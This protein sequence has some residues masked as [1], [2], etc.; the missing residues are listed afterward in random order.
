MNRFL[1][2]ALFFWQA[3]FLN[4]QTTRGITDS[5]FQIREVTVSSNRLEYFSIGNKIRTLDSSLLNA[6]ATSNLAQTLSAYSQVQINSYG[7]GL[8]NP[9]LRGTGSSHTA[10]L[11]NGFN[12]QDLLNGGVDCSLLPMN[13]FDDIKVQYGG[14]SALYGSGAIG[15]A[16][17]L[18]NTMDFERGVSSSITTGYGS[19]GNLFGGGSLKFSNASY[20]GFVKTFYNEAQNDFTFKNMAEANFPVQRMHNA[21]RSQYGVLGG[22]AFKLGEKSKLEGFFWF[23]DNDKNVAP[24]MSTFQN[25][26]SDNQRDKFYRATASWKTWNE[27]SDFTLRTGFSNYYM[28]YDTSNFRSIQ[29]STDAEYNFKINANHL[30]N[31]GLDYTYEKGVSKSLTSNAQRNRI[32]LFTSYRFTDDQSQWKAALNIRN[33][34]INSKFTPLTFSLGIERT[35]IPSLSLKGV[36]SKNYRVPTFNDLYWINLGNPNLKCESGL[37]EELGIIFSNHIERVSIRYEL[38]GFNNMVSNWILWYPHIND[39]GNWKPENMSEVWSRGVENDLSVSFPIEKCWIKTS[40]SYSYTKS[41]KSKEDFAGDPALHKQLIYVP[42]HKG[43]LSIAIKYRGFDL[44]YGQNYAG[45]RYSEIDHSRSVK[46]YTIGNLSISKKVPFQH[47]AL[48][49]GLQA[50]NLWNADYQV[51]EYYPMPGRNFQLNICLNLN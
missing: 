26:V 31:A 2:T 21:E 10:V 14:C 45:K 15:G 37:N 47:K 7:V 24:T 36:V 8:S 27:K 42:L 22:S 18:N 40:V 43:L 32:A 17:H 30:L 34:L 41:T 28:R 16:I 38:T 23:Q 35:M 9:S 50:N 25:P 29:S 11:W 5:V 19:F 3:V 48:I 39:R 13:F 46:P 20:S 44:Y 4:G 6:Y 51:M 33:E 49:F 12:L 1:L